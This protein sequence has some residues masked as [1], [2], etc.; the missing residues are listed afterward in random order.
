MSSMADRATIQ[1]IP[2]RGTN[3]QVSPARPSSRA[4]YMISASIMFSCIRV[5]HDGGEQ[6][7]GDDDDDLDDDVHDEND[8]CKH[9]APR[10][11]DCTAKVI[12]GT[13]SPVW[14]K[15]PQLES[16]GGKDVVAFGLTSRSAASQR[17]PQSW[18]TTTCLDPV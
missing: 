11:H 5:E 17:G 6:D 10:S 4:S 1:V 14:S 8:C 12:S 9:A 3:K 13:D 15:L 18:A 2:Y 7:D 16:V